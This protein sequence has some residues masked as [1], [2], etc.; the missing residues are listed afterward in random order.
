[1]VGFP[2]LPESMRDFILIYYAIEN[3]FIIE[4]QRK[5]CFMAHVTSPFQ[6]LSAAW[7]RYCGHGSSLIA[8]PNLKRKFAKIFTPLFLKNQKY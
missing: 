8:V 2:S 5:M 7:C 6:W 3:S 1:M 4:M